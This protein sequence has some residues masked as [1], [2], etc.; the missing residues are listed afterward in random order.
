MYIKIS[1]EVSSWKTHSK[2]QYLIKLW[3]CQFQKDHYTKCL[4][5]ICVIDAVYVLFID[6]NSQHK[7]IFLRINK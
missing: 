6:R 1:A 7:H 5:T 4:Q 3:E 2:T